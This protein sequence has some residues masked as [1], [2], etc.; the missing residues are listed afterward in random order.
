[1]PHLRFFL[2]P[3]ALLFS[4]AERSGDSADSELEVASWRVSSASEDGTILPSDAAS[5]QSFGSALAAAGDVDGDGY[6]DLVVGARGHDGTAYNGGAAYVYLGAATGLDSSSETILSPW[7]SSSYDYC[8]DAVA[9]AGDLDGDGYDDVAMGCDR[10]EGGGYDRG[11]VFVFPG[12]SSGIDT[13]RASAVSSPEAQNSEYFG[14]SVALGADYDGDGYDDLV[15]GADNDSHGGSSNVGSVYVF[16]GGVTG[17][18]SSSYD[19]FIASDA[20]WMDT[21]G[22]RA[23]GLDDLDGDGYGDLA[24]SAP[25]HDG[26]GSNAG[27][28]Y[29]YLGSVSGL[30]SEVKLEA[31]D[32]GASHRFGD[33]LASAGDVD[34]DGLEDLI[35]GA[36]GNGVG[37]VYVYLGST[38]GIDASSEQQLIP[39]TGASGDQ[40]GYA[41]SGVGDVD[42]DGFA[43]ILVGAPSDADLGTQ[44]GS[45]WLWYG[46]STGIDA[47]SEAQLFGADTAAYH[48]LGYA[49]AGLGDVDADGDD[50]LAIGAPGFGSGV[51]YNFVGSC[52]TSTYYADSDGDGFGDAST[53]T[54]SCSEPSGF[55]ANDSDCDDSD[56][57]V[58]P[59]A[60]E[61]CDGQDNDCDGLVD[62]ADTDKLDI[63]VWY[64]DDDM[65]GYGYDYGASSTRESCTQPAYFVDNAEDCDDADATIYPGADEV[66]DGADNDCDGLVDDDDSV[67]V[68]GNTYWTDAD[69]D[70]YGDLASTVIACTQPSGTSAY[71][72]SFD[73]DDSDAAINPKSAEICDGIDNDCDGDVDDD[74]SYVWLAPSW[75]ADADADG[76]GDPAATVDACDQPSGYLADDTDCDDADAATHPGASELADGVDND[77]DGAVDEGTGAIDDDGDGYAEDDGDCDDADAAVY[78]GAHEWCDGIDNDCDGAIDDDDMDSVSPDGTTWFVDQDGD[79]YGE[80]AKRCVRCVQP[81]G[82]VADDSD[83]DDGDSA[84]YPGAKDVCGDG[85]DSDCD[86]MGG[87]GTDED[88]DG[89]MVEYELA[90]GSSDCS[91]DS[92]GD[93][94]DDYEEVKVYRTDPSDTDSD[95]DGLDDGDEVTIHG[96]DPA[97]RDSDDD[98]LSDGEEVSTY[99][100]DPNRADSD[101]DKISD[102]VEVLGWGTD[103]LNMDTDG[104]GYVDSVELGIGSDPLDPNDPPDDSGVQNYEKFRC[105][106]G[107]MPVAGGWLLLG[108]A[109]V[110]AGR[111]RSAIR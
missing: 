34:A 99:G 92:D 68:G 30:G 41:V 100:T 32:G 101:G 84:V 109:V 65:D 43:D 19:K 67:V 10:F 47:S 91:T 14:A 56:G 40:V 74:D 104:D 37:A 62:A 27:A 96:T 21:F 20:G 28:V 69:G 6:N 83:C 63:T 38:T 70:G 51:V 54:S 87:P 1:M 73:C 3:C 103:P 31:T 55:V 50:D 89:L 59:G 75:Y 52:T 58:H 8:G 108:L 23:V 36:P 35:V 29:V 4:C 76:Y 85:V 82:Y 24:V 86:G 53:S 42:A 33:G 98:R 57:A 39:S 60:S 66:C 81:S 45:A 105:S 64:V 61:I 11:A 49:V 94:L 17:I 22:A 71:P 111:R 77:C 15:V 46:T 88:G 7:G 78:P 80:A 44:A 48:E 90:W 93:G 26:L 18:D 79:G 9:G 110:I 95:G 16:S 25:A 5:N 12:S 2:F 97:D 72:Y 102:G 107:G 13:A 106:S